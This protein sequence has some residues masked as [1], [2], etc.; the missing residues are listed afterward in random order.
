MKLTKRLGI[1]MLFIGIIAAAVFGQQNESDPQ[2]LHKLLVKKDVYIDNLEKALTQREATL[3][4]ILTDLKKIKT[5]AQLDSIK[6]AYG[7]D[8]AKG[9]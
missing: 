4:R 8:K 9:K 2:T 6:I 7:L 1:V 3:E 5:M